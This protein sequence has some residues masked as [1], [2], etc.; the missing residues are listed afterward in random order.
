MLAD[1]LED[2]ER[3]E[4]TDIVVLRRV[5]CCSPHGPELLGVAARR[6]RRVLLASYPRDRWPIRAA[7][8]LQN[9]AFRLLR[10]QFRVFVHPPAELESIVAERGLHRVR[11]SRGAIWETVQFD[12]VSTSAAPGR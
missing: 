3:L 8:R 2:P 11:R 12:P 7:V 1:L 5:V 4:P 9:V 6:T 10:K